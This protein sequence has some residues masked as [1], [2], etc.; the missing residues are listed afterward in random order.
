MAGDYVKAYRSMMDSAVWADEWLVKLWMWCLFKANFRDAY[1]K[2]TKIL[3]GQFITG[4]NTAADELGVSPSKWYRGICRLVELDMI[5]MNA[6]SVWTMISV[7]NY[8]TYQDGSSTDRTANEQRTDS[9][10]TADDTTNGQRADTSKKGRTKEEQ[11]GKK[12]EIPPNPQGGTA[13]DSNTS[14]GSSSNGRKQRTTKATCKVDAPYSEDF[15]RFWLNYSP[16]RKTNKPDAWKAWQVAIQTTDP[17]AV[18]TAAI[19]FALSPMGLGEY[20]PGPAP[21]L[22]GRRWEDDRTSWLGSRGASETVKP[23]IRW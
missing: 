19:D 5:T 16:V 23:P 15:E 14:N 11:E 10:R 6:N 2:Q 1:Y 20:C 3:R 4:R 9:E 17:Q 7:V 21:W 18:I 22:R 12:E 8:T 13:D